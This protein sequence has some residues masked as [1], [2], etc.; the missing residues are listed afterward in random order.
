MEA[1]AEIAEKLGVDI[2]DGVLYVRRLS[3]ADGRPVFVGDSYLPVG[4]FPGLRDADFAAVS[5]S[6][7]K[8][9]RKVERTRQW[10][11][12]ASPADV[13]A[14]LEL[15]PGAP[16]LRLDRVAYVFGDLPIESVTAFLHPDRYQ[17]YAELS[18]RPDGT[19]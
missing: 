17:H 4:R 14:L 13:A 10:I 11:V 7:Q 9:G 5:L 1:D 19:E 12:A 6:G 15:E 16:V 2:G 3:L 18:L 8:T